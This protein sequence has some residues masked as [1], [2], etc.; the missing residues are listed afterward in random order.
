M[1]Y[2]RAVVGITTALAAPL[3]F[4]CDDPSSPDPGPPRYVVVVSGNDQ[5]A[6]L[7][8]PVPEALVVR[9]LDEARIPVGDARVEWRMEYEGSTSAGARGGFFLPNPATSDSG[10]YARTRAVLGDRPGQYWIFAYVRGAAGS[11]TFHLYGQERGPAAV[12]GGQP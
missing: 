6:G 5:E 4:G 1:F 11:A 2:L 9:V 3:L 12:Q 7:G 10:G 8:E